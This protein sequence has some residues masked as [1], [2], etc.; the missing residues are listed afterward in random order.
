MIEALGNRPILPVRPATDT[1]IFGG[2]DEP[3]PLDGSG[4]EEQASR[5]AAIRRILVVED[6]WF[7]GMEIE[8]VL[9]QAGYEVV[10]V[11]ASAS[12]AVEAALEHAPDIALMDIRLAGERDGIDAAI[13]LRERCDVGSIFVSAHQDESARRGAERA[14][15]AGW[16]GKP[17]SHAQL[18][19]AIA[20]AGRQ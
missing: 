17:F 2:G 12:E 11:A 7:I 1:L 4:R 20:A 15:P 18:L 19:A 10:S 16:I 8:T 5:G 13:E 6:D 9:R 14:R 3:D